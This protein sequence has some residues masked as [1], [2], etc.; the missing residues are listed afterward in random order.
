MIDESF[1]ISREPNDDNEQKR[2]ETIPIDEMELGATAAAV[3]Y[4]MPKCI[5][6]FGKPWTLFHIH[7]LI[8][9]F[10]DYKCKQI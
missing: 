2:S 4:L 3:P 1:H 5:H 6:R 8:S 10:Y 9:L 7:K